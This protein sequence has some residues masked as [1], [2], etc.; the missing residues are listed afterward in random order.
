VR[1]LLC[2]PW[3]LLDLQELILSAGGA[4]WYERAES[5]LGLAHNSEQRVA[6]D[7]G[8]DWLAT[9]V[10]ETGEPGVRYRAGAVQST[11]QATHPRSR[12]RW[13]L[14]TLTLMAGAAAVVL[15]VFLQP[16]AH[17]KGQGPGGA[18]V[19]S[20]SWGWNRPDALPQ[21]LTPR[22]YVEHLAEGA[23]E[24]FNKRPDDSAAL[25]QRIREFRQGCTVLIKSPHGPLA[26]GDRTWL[27]EKC[28]AWAAKLDAHLAALDSGQDAS[29]I[30]G[31]ADETINKLIVA[32]RERARALG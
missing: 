32:L 23:R 31:E 7:R 8:L 27:I 19:A 4:Y 28:R 20:S 14:L 1:N 30:R 25:A 15:A 9:N 21:N 22:A 17:R 12:G 3:L 18:E 24:W 10:I 26:A 5:V 2:H 29:K 16:L 13:G 6:V 11:P